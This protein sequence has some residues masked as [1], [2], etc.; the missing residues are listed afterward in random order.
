V[1]KLRGKSKR[2]VDPVRGEG[3]WI[4]SMVVMTPTGASTSF[5]KNGGARL[6]WLSLLR[7]N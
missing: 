5:F 4:A 2:R 7:W 3:L 1:I 6:W